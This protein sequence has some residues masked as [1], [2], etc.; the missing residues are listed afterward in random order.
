LEYK[1]KINYI[2]LALLFCVGCNT[3]VQPPTTQPYAVFTFE[4]GSIVVNLQMGSTTQPAVNLPS[5]QV[6][7]T[8]QPVVN[9][10]VNIT[11]LINTTQPTQPTHL[12][13]TTK[14]ALDKKGKL[15]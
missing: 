14:P 4:P 3:Q 9:V 7:S 6:G 8:T 2:I 10:D 11:H 1:L 12:T 15:K 5:I 13:L